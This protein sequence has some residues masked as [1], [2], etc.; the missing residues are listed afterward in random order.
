VFNCFVYFVFFDFDRFNSGQ[1]WCLFG[2]NIKKM[3]ACK[4]KYI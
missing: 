4:M 1:S 3:Q 2:Y